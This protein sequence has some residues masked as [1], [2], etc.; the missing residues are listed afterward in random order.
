LGIARNE[1]LCTFVIPNNNNKPKA[2]E[3]L[4]LIYDNWCNA[5]IEADI[6]TYHPD[7]KKANAKEKRL[8]NK[9]A[10]ACE[11]VGLNPIKIADELRQ[12]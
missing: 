12:N 9:F 5:L 3:T 8:W 1:T 7:Y 11:K 6:D 2:M 4:K 10:M